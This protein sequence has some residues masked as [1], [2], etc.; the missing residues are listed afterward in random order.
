MLKQGILLV[1][2]M[3]ATKT[4]PCFALVHEKVKGCM[5]GSRNVQFTKA[6]GNSRFL[7]KGETVSNEDL[8]KM[9]LSARSPYSFHLFRKEV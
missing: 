2:I 4:M 1:T 6:R 9:R 5:P 8:F 3:I 7:F